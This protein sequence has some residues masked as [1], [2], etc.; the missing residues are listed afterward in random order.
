M[1]L[2]ASNFKDNYNPE[3]EDCETDINM[4]TLSSVGGGTGDLLGFYTTLF[5][6]GTLHID[7]VDF[8]KINGS[9]T[10]ITLTT[11]SGFSFAQTGG[12]LLPTNTSSYNATT[13]KLVCLPSR[14]QELFMYDDVTC[15]SSTL[16]I[17]PAQTTAPVHLGNELYGID[18]V[19]NT[20]PDVDISIAARFDTGF[21][22]GVAG[23]TFTPLSP[24]LFNHEQTSSATNGID[25]LY[26]VSG[27]SLLTVTNLNTI[28][29]TV[30]HIIIDL[31]NQFIYYGIE[32]SGPNKLIA[33]QRN[34]FNNPVPSLDLVEIDINST[35]PPTIL[36]NLQ[37]NVA[38]SPPGW[39]F[40]NEF[41]S[42]ALDTCDQKYYLSTLHETSGSSKLIEIDIINS[43][44]VEQTFTDYL[45]GIEM[46]DL[47]CTG[48]KCGTY[49]DMSYRPNQGAPN[50]PI[51]CG[52]TLTAQCNGMIPWTLD[53]NFMCNGS[54]CP[55]STEMFWTLT[56]PD[57][58][59]S[60]GQAGADP[61]FGI[62]I[63]AFE[64]SAT[65]LYQLSLGAICGQD[66]CYC[67]FLIEAQCDT[68][69]CCT[70]FD[71]FL[72]AAQ[73]VDVMGQLGD[74]MIHFDAT[75]LDSCMQISYCGAITL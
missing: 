16:D 45:F 12:A 19:N 60:M 67:D 1:L 32:Y 40:N 21:P 57:L 51:S 39:I 34:N 49:S 52:E 43:S 70:D 22:I 47:T 64:F 5:A 59:L 54:D 72:T 38:P 8:P 3:K 17:A 74:C 14:E 4:S 65:G 25:E 75:G 30:N 18:I 10:P 29:V 69:P 24:Y 36:Y 26:F 20:P 61:G 28:F 63:P 62:S 23:H 48:C 56:K 58:T 71:T 68:D 6:G 31:S 66:T 27:N 50:I 37:T 9:T 42:S 13:K 55:D 41:Y 53:G 35:S 11:V 44:H 46:K 15:G 2:C 33:I 73:S 7:V